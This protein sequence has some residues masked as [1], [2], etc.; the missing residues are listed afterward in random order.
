MEMMG[1]EAAER[2]GVDAKTEVGKSHGRNGG[3]IGGKA[4][5]QPQFFP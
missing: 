3:G 1:P 5:I 2:D 4:E